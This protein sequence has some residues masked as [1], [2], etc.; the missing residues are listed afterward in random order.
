MIDSVDGASRG[1]GFS[2]RP[3]TSTRRPSSEP[4]F[5]MPYRSVWS[6][7]TSTTATTLPPVCRWASAN[8]S[9]HGV[10]DRIRS[11]GSRTA[12]GSS[13]MN[14]WAHQ[15][16]W[17]S[18]CGTCWRTVSSDPGSIPASSSASAAA[19]P[20][21][22]NVALLEGDVE[23][24]DQRGLAA[25]GHETELFDSRRP[26]FFDRVLDQRL[27][28]HGQHFLRDRLGGGQ[29]TRAET[30]DGKNGFTQLFRHGVSPDRCIT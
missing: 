1:A 5:R 12:N 17:P 23:M 19:R 8:C 20:R 28:D 21:A 13:P 18:P 22:R 3:W 10:S 25:A 7:G 26:R 16:A 30:G 14:G 9:M 15:I 4:V 2:T 11:S 29:E 27:V 6:R 24:F